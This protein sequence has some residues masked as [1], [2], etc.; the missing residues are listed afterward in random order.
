MQAYYLW[1]YGLRVQINFKQISH[2]QYNKEQLRLKL[3]A[4]PGK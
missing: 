1:F 3:T 4:G 2:Y